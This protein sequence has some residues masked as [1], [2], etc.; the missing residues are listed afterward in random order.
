MKP[1]RVVAFAAARLLVVAGLAGDA[2]A[3]AAPA[4]PSSPETDGTMP[5]LTAIAGRGLMSSHALEDLEYLSDRIGGRVTGSSSAQR[6]VVWGVGRLKAIGLE[7]V[8][9]ESFELK[10]GWSRVSATAEIVVPARHSLLVSSYGWVGSTPPGGIE[11]EVVAVNL[12]RLDDEIRDEF[13]RWAGKV[14]VAVTRGAKPAGYKLRAGLLEKLVREAQ[15]ARAAAVL[16][17]PLRGPAAGMQLT[18]TSALVFD[19]RDEIPVVGTT[20]EGYAMIQ[21]FLDHGEIVR[22]RLD[23]Q[24]RLTDG[25][26]ESANVVGEVRGTEH[27]EQ[28]ILVGAH[29]DSWDLADGATDDAFGVAGVLGAAEAIQSSGYRPKRTIR[30]VLFTGEEQ[31]FLGSLAYTRAHQAEMPDFVA[32]L[33]L[34]SGQ[35]PIVAFNMGGRKDLIPAVEPFT[36]AVKAFGDI[37]LDEKTEFGTDTGSFTLQGVPA[38]NLEQDSPEYDRTHH[39]AAD[40]FDKVKADL[41]LRDATLMALTAYWIADRP[42]RLARPWSP[43]ETARMLVEQQVDEGLKMYGLWPFGDLGSAKKDG[44]TPPSKQPP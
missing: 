38:I 18:Q 9:T 14:L 3:T 39:S 44:P 7:G 27:P 35:G 10:R 43:E 31:R 8:H 15:R 17:G 42:G 1:V 37:K 11:T 13:R 2:R 33:I 16:L 40:T 28:V 19:D 41:L 29:L 30:F 5:G 25:P 4:E 36:R 22:L 23:V 34:D 24:N 32:V 12:F 6:A 26:V 21:R 20:E